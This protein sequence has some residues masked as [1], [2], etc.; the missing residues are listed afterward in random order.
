MERLPALVIPA[1][2]PGPELTD[3]VRAL[4]DDG[5]PRIVVVDDGSGDAYKARFA[6]LAALPRVTV[7]EHLVNLGKGEALKT[8]L[9]HL[10]VQ[11]PDLIGAVTVDAD[12][13]HLPGDVRRVAEALVKHPD[14][15]CLGVRS[16]EGAVPWKSRLGNGLTRR[17][18]WL[19]SGQRLRDTQTGLR[20]IPRDFVRDLLPVRA[21]RYEFELEMILLAAEHDRPLLQVPIETVYQDDN[22]GSHFNPVWDSLRVY[23]VFFRFLLSA[24]ATAILDFAAFSASIGLGASLLTAVALGRLFGGLFNFVVNQRLVFKVGR[25]PLFEAAR[26]VL[27]VLALGTVSYA[28]TVTLVERFGWNVYLAKLAA[29][30]SLFLV[31]FATQ[32]VFVFVGGRDADAAWLGGPPERT[33]WDAYYERP[34]TTAR[35]TRRITERL[36]LRF[37]SLYRGDGPVHML[38]LGGG[39]S[40]FYPAIR[41]RLRPARYTVVDDNPTG[42]ALFEQEHGDEPGV[43][44]VHADVRS[45]PDALGRADVCFSVG[46]IEHFDEAGT[47]E[48][49]DAHLDHTRAGGLVVLFFPTPTWLYHAARRAIEALGLWSFPDERPLPMAEVLRRVAPRGRVLRSGINWWIVLTQGMVAVEVGGPI[50]PP[51]DR[52]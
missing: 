38:E 23:F 49:I 25:E 13:Q 27:L 10:F 7:V 47:A 16:F 39:N 31:S 5:Y 52:R 43:S 48:V 51:P 18:L 8:G 33:D 20:G 12:G 4:L 35:F 15:L 17:V 29:E 11:F 42:L 3:L 9:N 44:L 1:Y 41:R 2:R 28:L 30:G 45:L 36:L 34:A 24:L 32:R 14:R 40:C 50:D 19:L 26:Y 21:S 6:E 46:L 37:F 22:R